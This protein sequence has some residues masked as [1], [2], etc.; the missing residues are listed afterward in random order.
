MHL[1]FLSHSGP[2]PPPSRKQN[3]RKKKD[4]ELRLFARRHAFAGYTRLEPLP[5]PEEALEINHGGGGRRGSVGGGWESREIEGRSRD[6]RTRGGDAGAEGG[7]GSVATRHHCIDWNYVGEPRPRPNKWR[8]EMGPGGDVW[9]EWGFAKV[10]GVWCVLV[11][12]REERGWV[13]LLQ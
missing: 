5:L 12:D 11:W 10:C 8:V 9:R 4:L 1:S 2:L 13:E 3:N 6:R 7:G